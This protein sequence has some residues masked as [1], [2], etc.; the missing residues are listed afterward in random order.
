MG[1]IRPSGETYSKSKV[2]S[3]M[4]RQ[5]SS[6]EGR[7]VLEI[8]ALGGHAQ[9]LQRRH[10]VG[11]QRNE[12]RNDQ[13]EARS[14][15]GRDLVAQALAATGRQHGEGA[16]PGQ[17]FADHTGL[18]PAKIGMPERAAQDVAR[19]VKSDTGRRLAAKDGRIKIH[20][21]LWRRGTAAANGCPTVFKSAF[22]PTHPIRLQKA[23]L[24]WH[25][26]IAGG[27]VHA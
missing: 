24:A 12:R 1:C 23:Q 8:E 2:P 19:D 14:Q 10:L 15:Q 3:L 27:P 18:Q 5:M 4:R 21:V 16:A 20:K 7:L 6:R 11:H 13:P 9:L 17:Q 22:S 25:V 26:R